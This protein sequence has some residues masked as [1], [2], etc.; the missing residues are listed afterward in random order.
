MELT[1]EEKITLLKLLADSAPE[2]LGIFL[3]LDVRQ[4][5]LT[6]KHLGER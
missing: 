3:I 1:G 4:K 2:I 5:N 6:G